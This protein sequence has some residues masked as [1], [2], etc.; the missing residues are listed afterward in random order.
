MKKK[1]R[2]QYDDDDGRTIAPMNIPGMPWYVEG[3]KPKK[4]KSDEPLSQAEI[5]RQQLMQED[6]EAY[7]EMEKRE[8]KLL[9]SASLKAALL[10]GLY[11]T[12]GILLFLLFCIFVW[13]R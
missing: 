4:R 1:E 8:T 5:E 10:V 2:K 9:V 12:V 6:P 11:F 7:R 13:F 3:P